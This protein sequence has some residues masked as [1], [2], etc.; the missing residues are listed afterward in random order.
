MEK[1]AQALI[2][3]ANAKVRRWLLDA[4]AEISQ[5]EVAAT[6]SG[7]R[8]GFEKAN[9]LNQKLEILC[10]GMR[11]EC[12][13]EII[14]VAFD[15]ARNLLN[16]EMNAFPDSVV[17]VAHEVLLTIPDA[18]QVYFRVNPADAELLKANKERLINALERAKDVDIRADK[19]VDRGGL[20]IQTESG[21]IDAQLSTHGFQVEER[22]GVELDPLSMRWRITPSVRTTYLQ[23]HRRGTS[24]PA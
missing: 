1:K 2:D 20:L 22:C 5:L 19:Q 12:G 3:E 23:F 10:Q 15:V 16:A 4:D 8:Q 21:V 17:R 9:K 14:S 11:D 18:K 13:D 6:E 7:Q 24:A